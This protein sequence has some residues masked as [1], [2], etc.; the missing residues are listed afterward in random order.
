MSIYFGEMNG[1]EI[2]IDSS[3]KEDTITR[4]SNIMI[5]RTESLLKETSFYKK[6]KKETNARYGESIHTFIKYVEE[7]NQAMNM[8]KSLK[9]YKSVRLSN[10]DRHR[11]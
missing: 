11:E 6:W 8:K 1:Y 3:K 2:F 4:I 10:F 7:R 9:K 5:F